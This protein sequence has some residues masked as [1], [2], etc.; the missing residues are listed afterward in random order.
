MQNILIQILI[1]ILKSATVGA[2]CCVFVCVCEDLQVW[3]LGLNLQFCHV[4][5]GTNRVFH[6]QN[7]HK[8]GL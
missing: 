7:V 6:V 4:S 1:L 8:Q 5:G 2:Y 3:K